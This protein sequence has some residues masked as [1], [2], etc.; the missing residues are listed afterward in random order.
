MAQVTRK[1]T[2]KDL[3]TEKNAATEGEKGGGNAN[4]VKVLQGLINEKTG[5]PLSKKEIRAMAKSTKK[6]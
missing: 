5:R 6:K 1:K 4:D 2:E 3:L